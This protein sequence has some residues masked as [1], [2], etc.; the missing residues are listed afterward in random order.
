MAPAGSS[1]ANVNDTRSVVASKLVSTGARRVFRDERTTV[2]GL[3]ESSATALK[4]RTLVA[5][6]ISRL[7]YAG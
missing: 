4:V 6:R 2:A 3:N 7:W 1:S 5:F